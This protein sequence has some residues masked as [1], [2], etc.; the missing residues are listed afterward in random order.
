MRQIEDNI[1]RDKSLKFAIRIVNLY[2]TLTEGRKE[3]II[4]KQV[5]RSGTSIGANLAEGSAAMSK[6]DF[7]SKTYIALK[8][9]TETEYWL[10]LL[11]ATDFITSAEYYS[12]QND[13]KEICR[14]LNAIC[15]TVSVS[16]KNQGK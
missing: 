5:L 12:I 8:E 13:C 4:A 14:L 10:T 1:V 2:K 6:K 9:A 7:L 15:K 3:F 16:L 11:H